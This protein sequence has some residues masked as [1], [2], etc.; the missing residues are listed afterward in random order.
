M[1]VNYAFL[2]LSI[3]ICEYHRVF[4]EMFHFQMNDFDE[5]A[6]NN[7]EK[8]QI[9]GNLSRKQP[10]F[11]SRSKSEDKHFEAKIIL[12]IKFQHFTLATTQ[13]YGT[14]LLFPLIGSMLMLAA[15]IF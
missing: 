15:G 4:Y 2:T 1:V 5:I 9:A 8:Q 11:I 10:V 13:A 14:L 7:V 6:K 3:S 12:Q